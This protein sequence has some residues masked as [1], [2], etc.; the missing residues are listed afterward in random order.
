MMMGAVSPS[1]LLAEDGIKPC[2]IHSFILSFYMRDDE[3]LLRTA[4]LVRKERARRVEEVGNPTGI[5]SAAGD[6]SHWYCDSVAPGRYGGQFFKLRLYLGSVAASS[7][8][9]RTP[10]PSVNAKLYVSYL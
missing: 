1:W 2:T 4:T 7:I 10:P 9:Q 8:V 3:L 6:F 5:Q